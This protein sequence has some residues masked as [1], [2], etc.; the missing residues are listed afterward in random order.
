MSKFEGLGA[1]PIVKSKFEGLGGIPV[2]NKPMSKFEGLGGIPVNN[3]QQ[4]QQA[5][6]PTWGSRIASGAKA[7]T[8]G[9]GGAIPDTAALV[10]NIPAL[11]HNAIAKHNQTLPDE[12]KKAY[13]EL[14]AYHPEYAQYLNTAE[15]P[16]IPS[17][18]EAIDRGIDSATG[19]YTD[20]PEDQKHIN[21]ALKFGASVSTGGFVAKAGS[22]ALSTIGK[23]TGSTDKAQ[24]AGAAAAGG[25][26]SY[27]SDQGASG[28][29]TLG[30][31]LATNLAVSNAVPIAKGGGNLLAK[32][33]LGLA[34]LGKSKFNLEVAKAGKDLDI[35][36][37]KAVVSEGKAIA[38]ADRFLSEAPFAGNIMQKRYARIG[39][40]ALEELD[41]AYE[42]VIPSKEL[43][44]IEDRIT[45]LYEMAKKTL[46]ENAEII[47]KNTTKAIKEIRDN[48]SAPAKSGDFTKI[49]TIINKI[50]EEILPHTIQGI[51]ARTKMLVNQ[52]ENL[53]N[54]IYNDLKTAK[55]RKILGDL[56]NAIKNDIAEYGKHNQEWYGYFTKADSLYSK[57]ATRKTLEKLLSGKAK[58]DTTGQLTYNSLS[59]VLNTPESKD[60]L[61]HL[62]APEIFKRLEKLGTVSQAMAR[63]N[64][65]TINPS[66]TA[67]AQFNINWMSGLVGWG[68]YKVGALAELTIGAAGLAHLLTDK[69]TLDLAIKFAENSTPTNAVKFSQRMRAITG[70]T[71]VTLLREAQKLEQDKQEEN[72]N[73]IGISNI[74]KKHIE[75]NKAKPKAQA[76]QKLLDNHYVTQ[77]ANILRGDPWVSK[78]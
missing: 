18:T 63:K 73:V 6:N 61:K 40:K 66:G 51:P 50:E 57:K 68:G 52:K 59:K 14:V 15:I 67:V 25:T 4:T 11:L 24:I 60:K 48:I 10:Y 9:V 17:A 34:G 62:V 33:A 27:L 58:S 43:A 77:G 75:E 64:K 55:G 54:S 49:N 72:P 20:T 32:S 41:K 7:I 3:N 45:S 35:N 2:N 44:G 69:K 31:G 46:P 21:E 38:I 28:A 71:P 22:K 56:N 30:G 42:S 29:K 19:G 78:E 26:M 47:P 70:Y 16:T 23:F 39:E 53:N 12:V 76:M 65:G 1:I 5:E 13:E 8:A 37:P 36:L 74:F